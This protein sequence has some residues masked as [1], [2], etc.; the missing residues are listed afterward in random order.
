M[1]ECYICTLETNEL[2]KCKCKNMFLHLECQFKLLEKTQDARCSI[3]L[4]EYSNIN[5]VTMEKKKLSKK[6]KI[7]IL[8]VTLET[9]AL[10]ALLFEIFVL[11]NIVDNEEDN[12]INISQEEDLFILIVTFIIFFIIIIGIKPIYDLIKY[13]IINKACFDIE[14]NEIITIKIDEEEGINRIL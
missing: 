4:E 3:C 13:I 8:F 2:S 14:K 5:I 10:G 7:L 9:L 12:T 1:G 6:S 11:L